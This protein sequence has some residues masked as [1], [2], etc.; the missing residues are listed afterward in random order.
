[1]NVL[2]ELHV[3]DLA[4]VEDVWLEFGPG[5]TVL[6]GE[7]GAGKTVLVSAL[8]LLLGERADSTLVREGAAEA[9]VEGRFM[10]DGTEVMVKRRV[11][12]EGRSRCSIDG[13]M[14]TVTMLAD[15]LGSQVDLHGQHDH[16][17]LLSPARHAAYLDRFIGPSAE[18]ALGA[19][20]RAWDEWNSARRALEEIELAL[21]DRDRKADYLHF[22]LS[23]I[24]AAN[25]RPGEFGEL[26]AVLPR[27][28]HGERL[29]AAASTAWGALREEDGASDRLSAALAALTQAGGLDPALDALAEAVRALDV[30]LQ[31]VGSSL[32]EY[33]E[34]IDHDPAALDAT[35][36]RLQQLTDLMRKYGGDMDA[37][38]ATRDSATRELALLEDGEAGLGRARARIETAEGELREVGERLSHTRAA[39]ADAFT[40]QLGAAAAEL[41]LP[42]ASFAVES[43]PL[44]FKSWTA[45]GPER[46]EFL[47]SPATGE[48][49][50]PLARIASGGEVSR[51]MLALKSVLGSADAVPILVFDE[52]DAGIG[53]ATA[54]TVGK[55]LASLGLDHQVLVIT[56][57]PQVA[58]FAGS[59]VVVSK[60][61]NEGRTITTAKRIAG[62]A[63]VIE[64]A[65]MLSGGSSAAGLAHARELLESARDSAK[66]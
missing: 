25:P 31:D 33:T 23:E 14:A 30:E 4:L 26:E 55:R 15:L 1:M 17:A 29:A 44:P 3:R 21:A 66:G 19:Y 5:L 38:M 27:L 45:E 60:A 20:R 62:D 48:T 49:P 36:H 22:Q 10:L 54:L 57:L 39:A 46:V 65:R 63:I 58:S 50:R 18:E 32:R 9:L 7:T 13:E 52:V 11:T 40:H 43:T 34:S 37:V 41:S 28:R 42:S 64:V 35:E 56:H 47:F 51:V 59:H 12:A 24:E 53:G 6:T 16:Q 2:T 61:E 8:K